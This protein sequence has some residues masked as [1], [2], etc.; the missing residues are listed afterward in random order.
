MF[1]IIVV[2][3]F[4]QHRDGQPIHA[5][6]SIASA[7]SRAGAGGRTCLPLLEQTVELWSSEKQQ[8]QC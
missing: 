6:S 2:Y 4:E 5:A 8:P 7:S 3:P 1:K